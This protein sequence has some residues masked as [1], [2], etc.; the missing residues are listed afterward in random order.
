MT[1]YIFSSVIYR[2][3][4]LRHYDVIMTPYKKFIVDF[5]FKIQ[6]YPGTKF[7]QD[8]ANILP[9]VQVFTFLFSDTFITKGCQGTPE[10]NENCHH[11]QNNPHRCKIKLEKFHSDI[12]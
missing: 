1:S 6:R 5:G 9:N 2:F 4:N 7:E 12:L 3:L 10:N 8:Q 11:V